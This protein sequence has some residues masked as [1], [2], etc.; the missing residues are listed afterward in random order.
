[1]PLFLFY[2]LTDRYWDEYILDT[3]ILIVNCMAVD[4]KWSRGLLVLELHWRDCG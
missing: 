1:M 3:V 2:Y 4:V